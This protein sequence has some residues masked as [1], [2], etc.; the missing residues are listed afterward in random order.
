MPVVVTSCA[1]SLVPTSGRVLVDIAGTGFQLAPFPPPLV[2]S[3]TPP[4]P[5]TVE[6]IVG[7][8]K[9]TQVAVISTTRVLCIVPSS[10]LPITE[11][12]NGEGAVDIVVQNIDPLGVPIV[13]EVDTLVNGLTY[14]RVQL[15]VQ[16]DFARL[17][18]TVILELRKQTI[19]EVSL[20]THTD[21]DD[22]TGDALNEMPIA[23]LP[24]IGLT[25]PNL[26]ENRF[27]S[28]NKEQ[29]YPGPGP[30]DVFSQRVPYTVDLEFG[31]VI[32]SDNKVEHLNLIA[33]VQGFF[34]RNT[35]ISMLR[36]PA[37]PSLGSVEYEMDL[38][39]GGDLTTTASGG[40]ES[41]IRSAAGQFVIRGFDL[42]DHA[43]FVGELV[44]NRTAIADEVNLLATAQLC[45]TLPVGSVQ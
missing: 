44:S 15:A 5:P 34:L 3:V 6:V 42:E 32:V 4:Q 13:G 24:A 40:A 39:E 21:W 7:G 22:D 10:M 17:V 11:P 9:A 2:G 26:T 25:G 19:A 28:E 33:L 23:K 20:T 35:K 31:I 36:D 16:T 14:Q 38:Q 30:K 18:A 43:G 1:P 27:Y 29:S 8:V 45:P 37:D 41:N 12:L